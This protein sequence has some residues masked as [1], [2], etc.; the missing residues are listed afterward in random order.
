MTKFALA[1]LVLATLACFSVEERIS[2]NEDG[3]GTYEVRILV[4]QENDAFFSL[5][6]DSMLKDLELGA[7]ERTVIGDTVEYSSKRAFETLAELS[8]IVREGLTLTEEDGTYSLNYSVTGGAESEADGEGIVLEGFHHVVILE[9]PGKVLSSNADRVSR[10]EL[11]WERPLTEAFT[12]QATFDFQARRIV[13]TPIIALI[14]LLLLL[15]LILVRLRGKTP[16]KG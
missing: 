14:L 16:N 3:S 1:S 15:I 8:E 13:S 10:N 6:A 2:L 11:V 7:P 9:L 4:P 12:A 5:M